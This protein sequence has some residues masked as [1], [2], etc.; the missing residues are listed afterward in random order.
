LNEY[1]HVSLD[2][3]LNY[4]LK[5]KKGVNGRIFEYRNEAS[6]RNECG[7]EGGLIQVGLGRSYDTYSQSSVFRSASVE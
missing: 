4:E 5:L 7:E 3:F 6:I 2:K 1:N